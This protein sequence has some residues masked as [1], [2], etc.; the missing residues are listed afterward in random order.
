MWLACRKQTWVEGEH[1]CSVRGVAYSLVAQG[2]GV[3]AVGDPRR[4]IGNKDGRTWLKRHPWKT[5]TDAL[6]QAPT[7]I[8]IWL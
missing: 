4:R 5:F 1:F 8:L 3:I 6:S 7:H 2:G